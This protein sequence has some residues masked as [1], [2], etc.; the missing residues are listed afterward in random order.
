[1]AICDEL[2]DQLVKELTLSQLS[3][4]NRD[5]YDHFESCER[6][7]AALTASTILTRMENKVRDFCP[8]LN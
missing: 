3:V 1:M 6:C 7:K 5:N 2:G 8:G 4:I